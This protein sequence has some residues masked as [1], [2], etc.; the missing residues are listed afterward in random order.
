MHARVTKFS[1]KPES[2]GQANALVEQTHQEVMKIPGIKGYINLRSYD[3]TEG[4]VITFYES[5]EHA[6]TATRPALQQWVKFT[7]FF[8]S[9]PESLG[10]DV[11]VKD[12]P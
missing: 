9:P 2:T 1:L 12:I 4:L 3:G 11:L 10:Y 6:D 5:R 8:E 7:E